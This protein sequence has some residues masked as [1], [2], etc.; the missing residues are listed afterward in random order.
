MVP[1]LSGRVKGQLALLVL[2]PNGDV[3]VGAELHL[4]SWQLNHDTLIY[5]QKVIKDAGGRCSRDAIQFHSESVMRHWEEL[6]PETLFKFF[7]SQI[8]TS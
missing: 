2:V 1:S 3:T 6:L 7:Q 5:F 4:F 8:L